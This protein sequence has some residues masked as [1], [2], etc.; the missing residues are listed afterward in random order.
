MN[1]FRLVT[2]GDLPSAEHND[3]KLY[4]AIQLA[5]YK[6]KCFLKIDCKLLLHEID[7]FWNITD[8]KNELVLKYSIGKENMGDFGIYEKGAKIVN[9]Y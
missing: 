4:D 1:T 7:L 5:E 2:M 8:Y 3:L 6:V 9:M